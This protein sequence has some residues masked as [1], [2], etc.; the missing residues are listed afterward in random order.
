MVRDYELMYIVRPELDEDGMKAA[1]ESVEKIITGT[2]GTVV[3]STSWGRRRLAYEVKHMRDGQYMLLH[4]QLEGA[5]VA[6][7]E[8]ALNISETV[9][10]HLLVLRSEVADDNVDAPTDES[11]TT[12]APRQAPVA[13]DED[14]DA[15]NAD[16]D[17]DD[18]LD[19]DETP[20]AALTGSEE[21]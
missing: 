21:V 4:V 18:D 13:A 10:R 17:E 8:R 16:D 5:K 11:G 3:S 14:D 2:G 9:F 15:D 20:A 19:D 6:E 7:A 12:A 1:V